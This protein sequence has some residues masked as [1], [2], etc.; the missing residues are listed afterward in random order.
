MGHHVREML[1][2]E[3][4]N[5]TR[6]R[7]DRHENVGVHQ[8]QRQYKRT[9]RPQ[10]RKRFGQRISDPLHDVFRVGDEKHVATTDARQWDARA[11]RKRQGSGEMAPPEA[12]VR[13]VAIVTCAKYRCGSMRGKQKKQS[14]H[15]TET[16]RHSATHPTL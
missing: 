8:R 16:A 7:Q 5:E 6:V 10:W 13:P 2:V 3:Q 15:Y 14:P 11:L 9:S 1:R 4:Q 12:A